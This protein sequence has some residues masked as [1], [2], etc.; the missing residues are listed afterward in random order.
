MKII[1][2]FS[3]LG[4]GLP[5]CFWVVRNQRR[6][7][8]NRRLAFNYPFFVISANVVW[9]GLVIVGT[10]LVFSSSATAGLLTLSA[11]AAF[12][13]F[14]RRVQNNRIAKDLLKSYRKIR[15]EFPDEYEYKIL[16]KVFKARYPTW[17]EE[18][19]KTFV[20]GSH[21]IDDL[22]NLVMYNETGKSLTKKW[23]R[24]NIP[25]A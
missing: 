7:V 23:A 9:I 25:N 20:R 10:V 19:I 2:G 21:N 8:Y 14:F 15:S 1:L 11:L 3:L 16:C 22:I 13:F 24:K 17:D 5:L 18:L 12:L 6:P 4:L